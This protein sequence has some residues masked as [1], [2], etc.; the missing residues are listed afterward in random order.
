MGY[1]IG[2]QCRDKDTRDKMLKFLRANLR[3]GYV[4]FE[5]Q[6]FP[7]LL[8]V[9]S[10][11][12]DPTQYP[13][14]EKD[15]PPTPENPEGISGLSYIHRQNVIGF[16]Y[17]CLNGATREYAFAILR[18]LAVAVGKRKVPRTGRKLT[19]P[20]VTVPVPFIIYDDQEEWPVLK[21]MEWEDKANK[22]WLVN[23]EGWKRLQRMWRAECR[24]DNQPAPFDE[25]FA[26]QMESAADKIDNIISEEL[27]RLDELWTAQEET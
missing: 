11:S 18:W 2:V 13:R 9:E 8:G 10:K 21:W 22:E 26:R 16:D 7:F 20:D 5:G 3:P 15:D 12:Y 23:E 4:L 19:D 24:P 17:G 25:E 27:S 6:E 1:S 14:T